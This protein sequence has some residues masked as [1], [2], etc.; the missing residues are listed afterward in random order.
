MRSSLGLHTGQQPLQVPW[1]KQ[2]LHLAQCLFGVSFVAGGLVPVAEVVRT[3]RA[4]ALT[5]LLCG[6]Q[7][8]GQRALLFAD[9]RLLLLCRGTA[10]NNGALECDEST[11]GGVRPVGVAA[12]QPP[13]SSCW[14][15]SS[16]TERL[17]LSPSITELGAEVIP[18][19]C[20]HRKCREPALRRRLAGQ[21][22]QLRGNH[23]LIRKEKGGPKGR[24]H[25]DG[26]EAFG[27]Y[28]KHRLNSCRC[29]L[30]K[31]FYLCLGEICSR[32]T[33]GMKIYILAVQVFTEGAN[34]QNRANIGPDLL[35]ITKE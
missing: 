12:V 27:S 8:A 33:I 34:E 16:A 31:F 18:L 30:Q 22:L 5:A 17:K 10:P 35:G 23:I 3:R 7:S 6:T 19:V 21:L 26:V 24:D 2:T 25:I 9:T 1:L 4:G 13:R 14:A 11:F 29:V 28:A 15:S 20:A 32:S